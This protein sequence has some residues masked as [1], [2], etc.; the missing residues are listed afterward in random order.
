M[1]ARFFFV[2]AGA[3]FLLLSGLPLAAAADAAAEV[4]ARRASLQ[5]ELDQLN[6]EIADQQK[7]LEAKHTETSSVERDIAIINAQIQKDELSIKAR[8]LTIT[9]L[10]DDI[11]EKNSTIVSLDDKL[12]REQ[13][14]LAEI[15]RKTNVIDAYT[16]TEVVLSSASVSSFFE[17]VN[18]F[19]SIETALQQ[20]FSQITDTK[21]QTAT[22]KADLED[23][24]GKE[25]ELRG[26]QV[27]QKKQVEA[28]KAQEQTLLSV[29][30]AEENQY[31]SVIQANKKIIA[32]IEAELFGLRDSAPI[33]FGT[34]LSYADAASQRTGVRSAFILG[35]LKQES[36]LGSNIGSCYVTDLDSGDGI[37]RNSST[38]FQKVMKAPRDTEPFQT[39]TEG[40]GLSWATA[41]VS[42][43]KKTIYTASRGYGGA[44]GPSQFIPSTWQL[45]TPRLTAALGE[46]NPDPWNARDAIMATALYLSDIGASSGTYGG[47]RNAACKYYSGRSC[48]SRQPSN[49]F[50]GDSVMDDT[51]FFQN[52]IDI[53]KG[54]T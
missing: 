39:I 48:D 41:P 28:N 24:R 10:T 42:C 47:E 20:S 1:R 19:A 44:M 9:S 49:Q 18:S 15:L 37:G 54:G 53:L 21:T 29:K 43:P 25:Q 32:G 13:Q 36:D 27:I 45:Y 35:V 14:S 5:T 3:V 23:K 7:I 12:G 26:Q 2:V 34:A 33:P 52:Q 30:K 22:A 50:Y 46:G 17:D 38:F 8:D 51:A 31:K 11:G 16:V 6:A 4:A 40:L